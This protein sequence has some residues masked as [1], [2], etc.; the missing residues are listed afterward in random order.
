MEA[1]VLLNKRAD[2]KEGMWIFLKLQATQT[3]RIKGTVA[4]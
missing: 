1:F 3:L 2:N 4:P